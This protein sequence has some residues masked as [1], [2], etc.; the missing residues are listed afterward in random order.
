MATV[1]KPCVHQTAFPVALLSTT[2]TWQ[3]LHVLCVKSSAPQHLPAV[4]A[5]A[6]SQVHASW[7]ASACFSC[8][9]REF[10][11]VTGEHGCSKVSPSKRIKPG[12]SEGLLSPHCPKPALHRTA[13]YDKCSLPATRGS[14]SGWGHSCFLL[15]IVAKDG[16]FKLYEVILTLAERTLSSPQ[17][18][19]KNAW[20]PTACVGPWARATCYSQLC[21]MA[22]RICLLL[23][24]MTNGRMRKPRSRGPRTTPCKDS[25]SSESYTASWKAAR[26][27]SWL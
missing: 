2:L 13:L 5:A 20:R 18:H 21:T 10:Q 15:L 19:W 6:A 4:A 3:I 25:G 16:Y 8:K 1:L 12:A 24:R 26:H 17:P 27:H 11:G 7:R 14:P 9:A 22:W 23:S